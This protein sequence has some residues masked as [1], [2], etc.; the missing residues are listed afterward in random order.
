MIT[1]PAILAVG[2]ILFV[3][4]QPLLSFAQ[5][6]PYSGD[7]KFERRPASY[8]GSRKTVII[9]ADN[10]VTE[11][12]DMLAPYTLFNL[13]G[14]LNV[15]IVAKE[16]LP[17]RIKKDLFVLPQFTFAE[18]DSLKIPAD[19]I[20]LPATS[21]RDEKQDPVVM[22]FIK[23][24]FTDSTRMLSVCDGASTAAATG[25]YDGLPIT[26][27]ASD[28]NHM[29]D[30]FKKPVWVQNMN[31]SHTA[32]LYSTAGVSNAVE[33]ALTIIRDMIGENT[34]KAVADSISYPHSGISVSH[35]SI[36]LKFGNYLTI[37]NKVIFRKNRKIGLVIDDGI[38]EFEMASVLDTYART[39]PRSF[40]AI[41]TSDS[42]VTT[43]YG[44][45]LVHTGGRSETK[46]DEIHIIGTASDLNGVVPAG[47]EI[48]RYD[49]KGSYP[50]EVCLKRIKE[51]YGPKFHNAVKLTLDYN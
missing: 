24:H 49:F 22:S 50:I 39:F 4:L 45:T 10:K 27:H 23:A 18:I 14:K 32:N 13:T 43:K 7:N 51:V 42:T 1:L 2:G 17:I 28:I 15:F 33:G 41:T 46:L 11:M 38:N 20:V 26:C 3:L 30:H 31:V 16:K 21:A 19:V 37:I 34:M 35:K 6:T 29:K 8:D 47:A 36:P 5:Y 40:S 9:V 44:L 48:I 12:F 25:F